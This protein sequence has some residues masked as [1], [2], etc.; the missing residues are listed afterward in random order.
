[1]IGYIGRVNKTEA[2]RLEGG[3]DAA[4]YRGTEYIGKE[5]IEKATKENCTAPLA[6]MKLKFL[7]VVEPYVIYL[8][9]HRHQAIT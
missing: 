2:E 5:G 7:R 8:V 4:N 3:D 6:T 1:M 9:P